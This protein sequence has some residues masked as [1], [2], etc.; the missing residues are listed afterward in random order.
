M[1][2]NKSVRT[3]SQ[4]RGIERHGETGFT[5][6]ELLVTCAVIVILLSMG[7][8]AVQTMTQN[9]RMATETNK[10]IST[11]LMARSEAVK[12]Q[13]EVIICPSTNGTACSDFDG[14]ETFLM[15][16]VD[17]NDDGTNDSTDGNGGYDPGAGEQVLLAK[18]ILSGNQV[19]GLSDE[20]VDSIGFTTN[21]MTKLFES[22]VG[23]IGAINFRF[24]DSRYTGSNAIGIKCVTLEIS[25]RPS[26]VD[27][28]SNNCPG[29]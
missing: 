22:G 5:L 7:I 14:T 25:G 24:N 12:R 17:D 21:G 3:I 26:I 2:N 10:W 9:N 11:M 19:L 1:L 28:V 20:D 16:F 23:S 29:F 15:V 13:Y 8:P 18:E 27:V 4:M 6:V